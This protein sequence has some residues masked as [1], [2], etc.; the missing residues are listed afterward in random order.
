[1][2]NEGFVLQSSF[3][4]LLRHRMGQGSRPYRGKTSFSVMA[5]VVLRR[6]VVEPLFGDGKVYQVGQSFAQGGSDVVAAARAAVGRDAFEL[7]RYSIR[8][9]YRG[10]GHDD[11]RIFMFRY[12][13][14]RS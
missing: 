6:Q 5:V 7:G 14:C 10:R 4:G 3:R 2:C 12:L 9:L 1:M 8:Q 13:G 11:A